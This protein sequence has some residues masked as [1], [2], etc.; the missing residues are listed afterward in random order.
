M[1]YKEE[2]RLNFMTSRKEIHQVAE[3]PMKKKLL[4]RRESIVKRELGQV[5]N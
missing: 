1:S 2:A 5:P 4:M 3:G